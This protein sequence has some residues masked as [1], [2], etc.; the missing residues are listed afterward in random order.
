MR[1]PPTA[2]Q[3]STL[4]GIEPIDRYQHQNSCQAGTVPL[5][6][7]W[8]PIT[9]GSYSYTSPHLGANVIS[10]LISQTSRPLTEELGAMLSARCSQE[11][12]FCVDFE[13]VYLFVGWLFPTL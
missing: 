9:S 11:E 4:C 3:Y 5:I 6:S 7:L 10:E 12:F 2:C 1:N 13:R 8:S